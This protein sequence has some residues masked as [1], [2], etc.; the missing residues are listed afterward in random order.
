MRLP[1]TLLALLVALALVAAGCGSSGGSATTASGAV[2]VVAT[3]TVLG[4]LARA[5]GGRSAD[6]H[7]LLQPNSDPHDYEPR[8]DDVVAAA[9]AQLLLESG[10]GLDA[11][12]GKVVE[13]SGGHPAVVDLGARVPARRR[14][15]GGDADPHWWHDPRNA[16]A[17]VLAIRDALTRANPAA[18]GVYARNAAAYASRLRAL[19][20][21]IGRCM[22]A[23]PP[24]RRKLVTDHDAFGYFAD[25]YGLEVVG[26]VIP[27]LTTQAQP[28]AGEL[29]DL[30]RTVERERVRTIFSE[31]SVSAKLARAIGRET[32]ARVDDSLYGDTLG[33]AGSP[34]ATYL[35][36]E[37]RNADAIAR[38]LSADGRGCPAALAVAT[39]A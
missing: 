28:S 4:D 16:A 26:T 35:G 25:R 15:A 21:A 1:L 20:A 7:Q 9:N 3:T 27:S 24:A 2:D 23:I 13:Q 11:W 37:A 14:G 38:G 8:P 33:P 6:V 32:G 31:Q 12:M 18:R 34:G 30:A 10:D 17:A 5:V 19:D 22:A 36:M 39:R 29:A